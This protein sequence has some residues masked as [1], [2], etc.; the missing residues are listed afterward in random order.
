MDKAGKKAE[1]AKK[2]AE[3]AEKKAIK[4]AKQAEKKAEKMK[5]QAEAKAARAEKKSLRRIAKQEKKA[6]KLAKAADVDPSQEENGKGKKKANKKILLVIPVV[7]AAAVVAYFVVIPKLFPKEPEAPTEPE[8]IEAPAA[9]QL[10]STA[11]PALPA[12][13]EVLV[14]KEEQVPPSENA[15]NPSN[16]S[17]N[18]GEEGE[19][20]SEADGEASEPEEITAV[21]YRYE[22]F[23]DP[24]A[25]AVSYAELML[26]EDAGFSFVNEELVRLKEEEFPDLEAASGKV[27]FAQNALAEEDQGKALTVELMWTESICRITLDTP[28]GRVKDPPPPPSPVPSGATGM[29]AVEAM[30]F[31]NSIDPANLGLSGSSMEDYTVYAMDGVVLIDGIP[32]M[33]MNVYQEGRVGANEIA[34]QY[35]ISSD[36]L[37]IY[38]L[39]LEANT[40]KELDAIG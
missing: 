39:D 11:I 40:V 36:G 27:F 24:H 38:Q 12:F 15:V 22:G 23:I 7:A 9:Y 13:G 20:D 19:A 8:P 5:K 35:F 37:H 30:D 28:E 21:T 4:K 33:S 25:L 32:C 16:L 26:T 1:K 34:G 3:I 29:T 10:G 31:F 18:T 6:E 17:A 14:Y 2:K